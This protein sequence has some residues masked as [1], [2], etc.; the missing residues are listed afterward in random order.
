M[1]RDFR[2]DP[3]VPGFSPPCILRGHSDRFAQVACRDRDEPA[4]AKACVVCSPVL[5]VN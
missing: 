3:E 5:R 4:L 1:P 2:R